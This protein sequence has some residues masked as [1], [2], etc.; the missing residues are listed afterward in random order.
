MQTVRLLSSIMERD[1]NYI[2]CRHEPGSPFGMPALLVDGKVRRTVYDKR[3]RPLVHT[4]TN[5]GEYLY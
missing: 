4:R 3:T 1:S 2:T 5:R